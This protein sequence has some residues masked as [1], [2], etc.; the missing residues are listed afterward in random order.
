MAINVP[1]SDENKATQA[2][3]ALPPL[4]G[5]AA[6]KESPFPNFLGW[7]MTVDHKIIGLM[8]IIFSLFNAVIGGAL[9][10]MMRAQLSFPEGIEIG[11]QVFKVMTPDFYNQAI[12][13]HGTLMV[14]FVV[15]P[16]FAGFGNYLIPLMI[17]ARDMAFPKMNAFAFWLLIPSA[18][19]IFVSMYFGTNA[20][21]WTSY[22]PLTSKIYMPTPG[23][24][25]WIMA[26]HLAGISTILGSINFIVT[27]ATMRAPGMGWFKMPLFCWT[28]LTVSWMN[29]IGL[30]VFAGGI[31]MLL[32]DRMFGTGFFDPG[33]G[34]DPLL[35]QH[36]FW[37]YNHPT[38]YIT[39]LPGFGMISHILASFSNKQIFGYKGMVWATAG[40]GVLSFLVWGHHM[41]SAGIEPWMRALFGFL[42]M[43]IAIPTGIKVFSWLATIWG[44]S[45]RFT[46]S[47]MYG[48]AFIAIFTFG[49]VT[50]VFLSNVPFDVQV[51]DS[52]FVVA[53]FHYT[54][55]GGAI[56]SIMGG[57]YFWFPKA[58]G[59]FLSEKLGRVSFWCLFLGFN[60]TFFPMHWLGLAGM[61]RRIYTY[62]PEFI[63]LNQ[64]ISVAY[65]LMAVGGALF[66][67]DVIYTLIKRPQTAE[68][69]V[70][71]VNE[72]Q[73]TLD[74]ET[75]SPPPK[76]N[77]KRI[78]KISA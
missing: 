21:G 43:L 55:F 47:M 53:H 22:P 24:D 18:L 51:H 34:G 65:I 45:I 17:G 4:T 59:R 37:F 71:K 75:S 61:A 50:G 27:I 20:A 11:G 54:Y 12:T 19:L 35:F 69:D 32:T 13:I 6:S 23:M 56:M 28:V 44:G 8:Y 76:Y 66:I 41:F 31:T 26:M 57:F 77:F 3:Q 72:M 39:V 30:P 1:V 60:L 67:Y 9:A 5:N 52:Y 70:W 25:M 42:T 40:I 49:G 29:I 63:Q 16:F 73:E 36:L 14:F 38:V 33:K 68:D 48:L 15:A 62:R 58:T 78:P 10:G 46:V 64:M 7:F 2:Q 74:W